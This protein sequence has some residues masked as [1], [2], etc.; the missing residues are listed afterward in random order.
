MTS[1]NSTPICNYEGSHYATEFWTRDRRYEDMAEHVALRKL[2]PQRGGRIIEIGAGAGRLA[3]LYAGYDQ[4]I[5]MDYARS[6]LVEAHQ[7]WGD[8]PRFR[9]V[10]ADVYHLPFVP[11]AFDAIV[12]VRVMHHLADVPCA[13]AQIAPTMR[14][15]ATFV[16][17]YANKHNLKAIVRWLLRRQTWSPFNRQPYEFAELNFDFHPSWMTGRLREAGLT[18]TRELTVSHFR[19]AILKKLVSP[20]ILAALDGSVQAT[21]RWWKLTPSVFVQT[22]SPS[23]SVSAPPDQLF[24]CPACGA[25]R[26][27]ESSAK[28]SCSV[29]SHDYAIIDNIV[30]LKP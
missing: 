14:P 17:E 28:L 20:Q 8:D 3:D 30:D 24:R 18:I 21:G 12:M 16:I 6:T 15:E 5:L 1:T 19:S 11:G 2:L 9:F 23:S 10:A 25:T 4:V 7:R 26:L 22:Q 13:L 27:V 29:C